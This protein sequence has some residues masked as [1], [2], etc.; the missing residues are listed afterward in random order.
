MGSWSRHVV[1]RLRA[2]KQESTPTVA[3]RSHQRWAQLRA[4][5]AASIALAGVG[6]ELL[7]AFDAPLIVLPLVLVPPLVFVT[8]LR[9]SLRRDRRAR[10]GP[11]PQRIE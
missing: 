6:L 5:L 3:Y 11:P 8:W 10:S 2:P 4:E 1:E 9:L 7:E